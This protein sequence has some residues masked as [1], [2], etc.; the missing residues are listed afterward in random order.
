M[1]RPLGPSGNPG[2]VAKGGEAAMDNFRFDM[3]SEG[4]AALV[5]AMALVW[6]ATGNEGEGPQARHRGATHYAVRE[7]VAAVK[8]AEKPYLDKPGKPLRMVFFNHYSK[9][10]HPGDK[11]ALPFR[12]DAKGAADFAR[13]WLAEADYGREPDHDGDNKRGW[14]AYNEGWGHVDEDHYSIIAVAP[15]WAMYGK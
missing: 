6:S 5:A 15:S 8:N 4:D 13:R 7:A 14:R 10:D 2:A 9:P 3:T 11:V 1:P 12:L